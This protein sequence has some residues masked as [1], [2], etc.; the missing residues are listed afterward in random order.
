MHKKPCERKH[1]DCP[2]I[3]FKNRSKCIEKIDFIGGA[4]K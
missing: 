3:C 1:G 4:E 2:K